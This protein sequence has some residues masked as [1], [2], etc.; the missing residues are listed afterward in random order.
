M[1]AP[2]LLNRYPLVGR[3]DGRCSTGDADRPPRPHLGGHLRVGIEGA[4]G[5]TDATNKETV[6]TA[7]ALANEIGRP[8]VQGA[9]AWRTLGAAAPERAG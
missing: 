1:V 8:V 7:V 2:T 5:L 6:D 9:D 4:G 3:G